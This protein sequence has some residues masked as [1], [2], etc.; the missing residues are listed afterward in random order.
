MP[1]R[2]QFRVLFSNSAVDDDEKAQ[3][4]SL[5]ARIV[6]DISNVNDFNILV[7]DEF[8]RRLKTLVALNCGYP[9]VSSAW[10]KAC[11]KADKI[12]PVEKYLLDKVDAKFAKAY[13]FNLAKSKANQEA[14]GDQ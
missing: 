6:K 11:V 1:R 8:K 9:I 4:T 14:L 10:V 13:G 7:T 3:M 2:N 12:L 5:G